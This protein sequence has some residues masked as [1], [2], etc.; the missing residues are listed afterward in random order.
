VIKKNMR[1]YDM[2][3]TKAATNIPLTIS[4]MLM[5]AAVICNFLN[6]TFSSVRLISFT[7]NEQSVHRFK[8]I[9]LKTY[10]IKSSFP[11]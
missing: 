9:Y 8:N 7:Q 10:G 2:E 5:L 11:T 4:S 6:S 3:K 1:K